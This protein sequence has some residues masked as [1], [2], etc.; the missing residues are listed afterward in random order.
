MSHGSISSSCKLKMYRLMEWGN[1]FCLHVCFCPAQKTFGNSPSSQYNR[2]HKPLGVQFTCLVQ[3]TV[4]IFA[5]ERHSPHNG[6]SFARWW[7]QSIAFSSSVLF[8][9]VLV[10]PGMRWYPIQVAQVVQ[11]FLNGT[12]ICATG[13]WLAVSTCTV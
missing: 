2:Q 6:N 4:R 3:M 7:P 11:L 9:T 10:T 12:S 5:V 13:R 8:A 1:S